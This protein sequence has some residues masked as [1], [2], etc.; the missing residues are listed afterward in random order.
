MGSAA[1]IEA[2]GRHKIWQKL[3]KSIP[4][5]FRGHDAAP[6]MQSPTR[7]SGTSPSSLQS[8]TL[9][10]VDH[11]KESAHNGEC[12][13]TSTACDSSEPCH[14]A[15]EHLLNDQ[16]TPPN[17]DP[18]VAEPPSASSQVPASPLPV[19]SH[20]EVPPQTESE[21]QQDYATRTSQRV[22]N[23][24]YDSLKND[25][26]TAT[27]VES[28]V[29]TLDKALGTGNDTGN[30]VAA[31]L[32]D[33]D[34]RQRVMKKFVK[35]GQ[36]KIATS[37]RLTKGVGNV[38]EFIHK[39]KPIVDTAIGNLPQAALPWVGVC[40]G[41]Q[42]LL[43]PAKATNSNLA[44]IT[45]VVSRME[46]YCALTVHL[47]DDSVKIGDETHMAVLRQLEENV[48][49]LYKALLL[50]QMKSVCCYYRHQG[51]V[52][53]RALANL[54]DW[55]ADLNAVN[56]A[57][58]TLRADWEQYNKLRGK[59]TLSQVL[60]RAQE[61]QRLLGDIQQTLQDFV[62]QQKAIRRDDVE[63]ACRRDLCVVD[64]QHDM[65][66]IRSNKDEIFE[67]AYKWIL[68]TDEYKKFTNWYADEDECSQQRLLWV[69]GPSGTGKTMLM[70]GIIRELS[71]QS[72]V[73]APAL[74]F[75]ICQGTNTSLN[76]AT[77]VLRSLIWL[78]LIQQPNLISHLLPKY[79]QRGAEFFTDQNAFFALSEAFRNILQDPH[80]P[81]VYLAVDALDECETDL[82]RLIELISASLTLTDRVKWV[83]SSRPTVQLKTSSTASSLVELDA[84]RLEEPVKI[85]I[86]HKLAKLKT[87][88]G[89]SDATLAQISDELH[90]RAENTFLWVALVCK[91]LESEY[92]W[93]AVK[94]IK[95]MPPGLPKLYEHMM[96]K[97]ERTMD[98]QYCKRV[99]EAVALTYRP[100]SLPELQILA[101]LEPE[102]DPET[103]AEECGSFLTIRE[104][105]VY[106]I[107]QSAKDFLT[108][109]WIK[110]AGAAERHMDITSRSIDAM[111]SVLQRNMYGLDYCSKPQERA[112]T[113]PDRHASIGYSCVFWVDHL[114]ESGEAS[115]CRGGFA[116]DDVFSFLKEKLLYWLESL[117]LLGAVPE[118]LRSIQRLLHMAQEL[119]TN[120]E[121]V[122]FL[123]DT[124]KVVRSHRWI[125]EQAPLQVYGSALVFSPM[126]SEVRATQWTKRLSFIAMSADTR[127]YW[128][129]HKQTLEGHIDPIRAIAFSPD[130]KTLGSVSHDNTVR[131]WDPATGAHQ[132]TLE[133]HSD[134]VTG[135]AFSPDGKTLAS[136]S[137]DK[138][139]RL[140]DPA[141][142]AHQQTFKGHSGSLQAVAFS[143]DGKTLASAS[144][145]KTVRLWD[146]ATGAHRQTLEVHSGV[147]AIAFSPDGKTL[148]A[149]SYDNTVQLWDPDKG[150]HWQTLEGHTDGVS[151]VAFTPDGKTLASA[152]DDETVRLWDPATGAH[153][154]TLKGHSAYVTAVA[155]SPDGKTL[156]STSLDDTVR[157]WDPATGAHQQTLKAHSSGVAAIA[158]S[159]DG[160][161]LASASDDGT[162]RL[163]DPAVGAHQQMLEGHSG[164]ITAIAFSSNGKTLASASDDG[165]VRLW[166]PAVG[167]HQQT[168]K[169]HSAYVTAVVF[170]PDGN[171]LATASSDNTVRLW[172]P[173][174]G[175]HQQTLEGH[176]DSVTK[177]VFS[178]DGKALA[179]TSYDKT[180]RLWHTATGAHQQT[181]EGHSDSVTAVAFSPDGK[182]L[183]SASSDKTVR[184]WDLATGAHQQTLE[185]YSNW[186]RAVVFSPDGKT[187][188]SASS[189]KTVRFWDL[190]TGALLQTLEG[191]S[192]WIRAV[193]FSPDGRCLTTNFGSLQLSSTSAPP[194]HHRDSHPRVHSLYV[195]NDWITIDGKKCL[196]LP[197][198][199][200]SPKVAVYANM[201]VLGRQSGGLTFLEAKV[202]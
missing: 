182:T 91:R 177:V 33:S 163:W 191:Y 6:V 45:H 131:L 178:P 3:K 130:G 27:L 65:E 64:P 113:Q 26:N 136:A 31:L 189:H 85:Y 115:D 37:S 89:Y 133:G 93:N 181:L 36:A 66:R 15:N 195:H 14:S 137:S 166:D 129:A 108:N 22:W 24:A 176:S 200:R 81:P 98:Q 141:T 122:N 70:I 134:W 132:Q 170:S 190:A 25:G 75:F 188:A 29:R 193:A 94:I 102:I 152:S 142:G 114:L 161:T 32:D 150:T 9:T 120:S 201:I 90:Q 71:R 88:K 41:L 197:K 139:V 51:Y 5:K 67:D 151:A 154:Q 58:E 160:K 112:P 28:Y 92:G 185:G 30:G 186:I 107:H 128:D 124:E 82:P 158:F 38:A 105:T 175:A 40:V 83:V 118:G 16:A 111:S 127:Q 179:T 140:W 165:T 157:L 169:G 138:T 146:P 54:D 10:E 148:A 119:V 171:T 198:D 155:F 125:I 21:E 18:S 117:S 46:W 145:D 121:F 13:S 69:K 42:I 180:V 19:G 23:S 116:N 149:G 99:L 49:A 77:A 1:P 60:N 97:L 96:A 62:V 104:G 164:W 84:Q 202:A 168:L 172:D 56:D 123:E 174:T 53:L 63:A 173:A 76:S 39:I 61:M 156:A 73:L 12:H 126:S 135:I 183:A 184:L 55:D 44:G 110:P 144:D 8:H 17:R 11:A 35:A 100:L 101:G 78:L 103:V 7:S 199:Y 20:A 68:Q 47:L 167:A 52:F 80:L 4:G 86:S 59:N 106:L 57:E 196:W 194:D 187:L 143:P 34:T 74:S 153:Q 2:M 48:L 87:R 79:E 192:N 109:D 72:A 43:N 50:Y 147:A 95:Q 159:P 162:V